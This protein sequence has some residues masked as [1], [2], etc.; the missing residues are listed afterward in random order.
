M[1]RRP[2]GLLLE[3][4]SPHNVQRQEEIVGELAHGSIAGT[5]AN[6]ILRMVLN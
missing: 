2:Q 5:S 3:E 6:A 1:G 4:R